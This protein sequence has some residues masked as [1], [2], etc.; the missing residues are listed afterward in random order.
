MHVLQELCIT[1]AE[2]SDPSDASFCVKPLIREAPRTFLS[3]MSGLMSSPSSKEPPREPE[4]PA[5]CRLQAGGHR[6]WKLPRRAPGPSQRGPSAADTKCSRDPHMVAS[7]SCS[8]GS[9][10]RSSAVPPLCRR[11]EGLAAPSKLRLDSDD[12][13]KDN[14]LELLLSPFRV[15]RCPEDVR[16][17]RCLG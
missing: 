14:A 8:S 3:G 12:R 7:A 11:L 6:R 2:V 5:G 16:R 4:D 10:V 15:G 13:H 9:N 17:R 1:V